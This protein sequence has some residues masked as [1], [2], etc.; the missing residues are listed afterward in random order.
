M[1]TGGLGR[2]AARSRCQVVASQMS[3]D[4]A[5]GDGVPRIFRLVI[6]CRSGATSCRLPRST[7]HAREIGRGTTR[8]GEDDRSLNA[9]TTR[10]RSAD[11][12]STTSFSVWLRVPAACGPT[13][14]STDEVVHALPL[15]TGLDS[16][17]RHCCG[18]PPQSRT[19]TEALR[20]HI[21]LGTTKRS[22]RPSQS[23]LRWGGIVGLVRS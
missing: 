14:G 20:L 1:N 21:V 2:T 9:P 19:T 15:P 4:R 8:S 10:F 13:L 17:S 12:P 3:V 7:K 22:T 23:H 5:S 18:M 11:D 6:G 16:V